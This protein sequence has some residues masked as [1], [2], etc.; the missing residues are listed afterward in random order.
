MNWEVVLVLCLQY[1]EVLE[2]QM[3]FE[4]KDPGTQEYCLLLGMKV[5]IS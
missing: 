2:K 1:S 4:M 5:G 3:S